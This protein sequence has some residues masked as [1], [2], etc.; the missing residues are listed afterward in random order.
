MNPQNKN[1]IFKTTGCPGREQLLLY[2][3]NELPVTEKHQVEAHLVDCELCSDAVEG[4]A[5]LAGT[6]VLDETTARV[7]AMTKEGVQAPVRAT[8]RVWMVAASVAVVTGFTVWLY[9]QLYKPAESTVALSE[10]MAVPIEQQLPPPPLDVSHAE[11]QAATEQK[12]AEK[13]KAVESGYK[14]DKVNPGLAA[15]GTE[16]GNS[17]WS[18]GSFA[19]EAPAEVLSNDDESGNS[20]PQT[21]SANNTMRVTAPV[22]ADEAATTE[23]FAPLSKKSSSAAAIR[24]IEG[25]KTISIN[26][27]KNTDSL[28]APKQGLEA[29]YEN[30]KSKKE[31]T[32]RADTKVKYV[33][34]NAFLTS[35]MQHFKK[36]QYQQALDIFNQILDARSEDQNALFYGALSLDALNRPAEA[37]KNLAKIMVNRNGAFYEEAKWNMALICLKEGNKTEGAGLLK[38]IVTEKGFYSQRA[39]EKLSEIK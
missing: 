38:E 29:M 32:Y 15:S 16:S 19:A 9:Y 6:A 28:L 20:Q 26:D 23:E 2:T 34:Y 3:K 24:Y 8:A 37:K 21:G 25:L 11:P 12:Q 30:E 18:S 14:A 5:L 10:K 36:Q 33:N 4:F 39:A 13:N 7:R 1:I 17:F 31:A 22:V 35:G 27:A